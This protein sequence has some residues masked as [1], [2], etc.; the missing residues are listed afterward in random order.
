MCFALGAEVLRFV[1]TLGFCGSLF[2]SLEPAPRKALAP[3]QMSSTLVVEL[4]GA[5]KWSC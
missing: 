2:H 1:M 4:Q 3:T 5:R